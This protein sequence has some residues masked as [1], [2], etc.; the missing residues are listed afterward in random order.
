LAQIVKNE[1]NRADLSIRERFGLTLQWFHSILRHAN[2]AVGELQTGHPDEAFESLQ[3]AL[4]VA[5]VCLGELASMMD[6][7]D[8]CDGAAKPETVQLPQTQ[9]PTRVRSEKTS[10]S[11]K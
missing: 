7:V 6:Q 1:G 8:L 3:R 11:T 9:P 5:G 4:I 10:P 2:L